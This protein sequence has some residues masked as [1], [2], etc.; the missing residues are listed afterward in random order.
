M[1]FVRQRKKTLLREYE[2]S[3]KSTEFSDKRIGEQDEELGEF[4][5][6]ILRSQRERKV[7]ALVCFEHLVLASFTVICSDCVFL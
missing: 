3:G 5:K 4:D 6:A 2:Q 7:S 1:C